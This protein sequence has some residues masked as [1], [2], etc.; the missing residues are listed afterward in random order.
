M[1]EGE[2]DRLAEIINKMTL[3]RRMNN[4]IPDTEFIE[5]NPYLFLREKL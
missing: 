4:K 3:L 5:G 2:K 1:T